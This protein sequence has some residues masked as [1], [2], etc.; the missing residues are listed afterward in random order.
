MT[1]RIIYPNEDGGI[2]VI[3]PSPRWTGSIR[4]LALKD[5]PKGQPFLIVPVSEIPTDRT[6]REAWEADFSKPDGY[7]A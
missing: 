3:V 4:D 5:V 7:G 2:S 6:Y 1:D